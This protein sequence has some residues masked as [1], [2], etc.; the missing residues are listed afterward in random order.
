MYK[1]RAHSVSDRIVSIG[2]PWIRP[3][4][5]GRARS[6][7]EFGAELDAS[8]DGE[9][10]GR[11]EKVSYDTYNESICLTEAVER[12]R[13]RTGHYPE[14]VLA[15]QI[16][17]TRGN[18]AYCKEHGIRLSGPEPSRPSMDARIDKEQE[19][20][21]QMRLDNTDRIEVEQSFSRNKRCYGMG[22]I[23]TK[24]EETQLASIALSV[25][26]PNLFNIQKRILLAFIWLY[27]KYLVRGRQYKLKVA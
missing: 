6:P 2:Q 23:V 22:C 3:I 12:Y 5:R 20:K 7:I 1:N 8:I 21:A 11:L 14:R 27:H 18:R 26:V 10:Y 24:L 17:R 9:G 16:Y 25:F 19:Y 13:T 4:V 15:D